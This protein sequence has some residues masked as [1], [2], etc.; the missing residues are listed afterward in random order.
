[1]ATLARLTASTEALAALGARLRA[2]TEGLALDP[3]IAAALDA[4]AGELG[5]HPDELSAGEQ[6]AV[7]NFARAFLRQAADLLEAPERPPGWAYEDPVVLVSQG[8]GSA[9]VAEAIA[10]V[11]PRLDGLEA[12]LAG[13]GAVVCDVG[14]G[15]AALSVALCRG[16]PRLRVVALDPWAPALRLA[17]EEVARAGME[18]RIELRPIRIEAL[19]DE[20]AFDAVWLPGI[21]LPPAVLPA[22]LVRSRAALKPDGWLL[23][24]L[25]AA[26]PDPLSQRL[27]ELRTIRS[28]GVPDAP[29]ETVA[30]L[31]AAGFADVQALER[32]W[33]APVDLVAG[34]RPVSPAM[35]AAAG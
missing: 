33:G 19:G 35:P 32:T 29:A 30:R 20:E 27:V 4:V 1:M 21:F 16:W 15:V 5:V 13:E 22:A 10:Q 28:G 11:A 34:R 2:E 31:K 24:G 7:A 18:H 9:T 17:E 14:C 12:A 3:S 6:A 8:R 26:S 25:Y 23:F